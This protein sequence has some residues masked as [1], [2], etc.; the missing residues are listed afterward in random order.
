VPGSLTFLLSAAA[1]VAGTEAAVVVPVVTYLFP[2]LTLLHKHTRSLLV[3][4]VLEQL[5]TQQLLRLVP[6]D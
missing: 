3:P 6:M 5:P 1:P 4:E 2:A